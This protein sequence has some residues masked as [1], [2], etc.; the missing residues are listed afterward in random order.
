[1]AD[2]KSA[3]SHR[4]PRPMPNSREC[5]LANLM[6]WSCSH[7]PSNLKLS[8]RQLQPFLL[9]TQS[10]FRIGILNN[11]RISKFI[12]VFVSPLSIF[13]MRTWVLHWLQQKAR[14]GPCVNSLLIIIAHA[15]RFK[16][17]SPPTQF[18]VECL[19]DNKPTAVTCHPSLSSKNAWNSDLAH[20]ISSMQGSCK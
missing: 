4:K 11:N 5:H 17:G 10:H 18:T 20:V 3:G 8:W 14:S 13:E 1:M 19:Q 2:T 12:L 6:A 9:T 7:F 15:G 16:P